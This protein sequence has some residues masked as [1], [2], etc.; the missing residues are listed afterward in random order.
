VKRGEAA[1]LWVEIEKYKI[2][3]TC[4]AAARE[5]WAKVGDGL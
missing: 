4:L 3:G 1:A 2:V 5:L